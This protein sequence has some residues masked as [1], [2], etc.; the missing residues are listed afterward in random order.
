[1]IEATNVIRTNLKVLIARENLR[2]AEQGEARLT[3]R[4]LAA[5]TGLNLSSLNQ[6]ATNKTKRYD[7]KTID[8]LCKFFQIEVGELLIR[9][10]GDEP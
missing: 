10:E 6:L 5:A 1:M 8:R 2:R 9:E 7:A 3:M 4:G